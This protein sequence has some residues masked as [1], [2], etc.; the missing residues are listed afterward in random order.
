MSASTRARLEQPGSPPRALR[1]IL[2][3]VF[4]DMAGLG[5]LSPVIPEIVKAFRTDAL[6]IGLLALVYSAAQFLSN[7]LLG[8]LSDR[9]GRKPVLLASFLGSAFTY[10]AFGWAPA[11]WVLFLGRLVDGLT[12]ANIGTSQ[13]YIADITAPETRSRALG[14]SGAALGLGFVAGPLVGWLMARAGWPPAAQVY[15][16]A[17]LALFSTLLAWWRLPES[18]PPDRRVHRAITSS[19]LNPLRP[20]TAAL[21]RRP[22]RA[23]LLATFL[24]NLAMAGVRSHFAFFAADHLAMTVSRI[25]G[26]MGFLGVMMV[27]AQGGL[28]RQCVHRWGDLGTLAVGLG[29]SVVGF[30]GLSFASAGWPLY[31]VVA[32]LALGVGL[33]TPTM[34]SL[35]SQASAVDE[36][37]AMLGSAQAAA[38]LGQVAG[39]V[40]AGLMYD[41]VSPGSPFSTGAACVAASLVVVLM[42]R[43]QSR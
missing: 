21:S 10:V 29:L 30:F 41:A 12:G 14:L 22:L 19:T 4:L 34:T 32:I 42:S 40:W 2:L 17:A 23:L 33:A 13:A 18:L 20:L 24:A 11:L 38:A 25:Y 6:T 31:L 37:G 28:V 7:P 16:A 26:V 3:I 35:I 36:Q 9:F 39:P 8:A 5:L 15:L 27:I 43:R 1:W